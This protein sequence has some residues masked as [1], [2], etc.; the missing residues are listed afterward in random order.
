LNLQ[1][2][3]FTWL[4]GFSL[5]P[6]Q[7]INKK[8]SQV[9]RKLVRSLFTRFGRSLRHIKTRRPHKLEENL[10]GQLLLASGVRFAILKQEVFTTKEKGHT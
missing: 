7:Y 9:G 2:N 6:S 3:T 10:L 1:F 5:F 4:F 8:T